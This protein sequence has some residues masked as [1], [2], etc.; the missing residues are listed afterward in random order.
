MCPRSRMA[1]TLV[2]GDRQ[3]AASGLVRLPLR[4]YPVVLPGGARSRVGSI[5]RRLGRVNALHPRHV[6]RRD[7]G[8]SVPARRR[9]VQVSVRDFGP[10]GRDDRDRT[11]TRVA[12]RS[13]RRRRGAE[14]E[15]AQGSHFPLRP[16]VRRHLSARA[17]RH[18]ARSRFAASA[19]PRSPT[20]Y[21]SVVAPPRDVRR[22]VQERRATAAERLPRRS[23]PAPTTR[24][25][26]ESRR[27][28]ARRK[29]GQCTLKSSR[30]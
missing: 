1:S 6:C 9:A 10:R 29:G 16:R 26:A 27:S 15:A 5:L 19:Q 18:L 25:T 13:R 22:R 12:R 14:V 2:S 8:V 7:V 17:L 23:S 30:L 28:G 4:R 11:R 24:V 20:P 21:A 3:T